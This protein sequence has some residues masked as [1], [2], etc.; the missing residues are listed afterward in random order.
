MQPQV[1]LNA[2]I[3][4]GDGELIDLLVDEKAELEVTQYSNLDE[5]I[6]EIMAKLNSYEKDLIAYE[7]GAFEA[8]MPYSEFQEKYDLTDKKVKSETRKVIR[9]MKRIAE[10]VGKQMTYIK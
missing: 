6:I 8:S 10:Q 5:S 9:K 1:S 3:Y 2:D 4:D 7:F